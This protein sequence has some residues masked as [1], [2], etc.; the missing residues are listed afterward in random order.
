V[1]D[2]VLPEPMPLPPV[3]VVSGDATRRQ[4][5][6]VLALRAGLEVSGIYAGLDPESVTPGEVVLA[7]RDMAAPA[8]VVIGQYMSAGPGKAHL[9]PDATP[10]QLFAAALAV[11]AGLSVSSPPENAPETG[12]VEDLTPREHDVLRLLGE[13]LSNRAIAAELVISENTVKFHVASILGKLGA[14]TRAEA[15][16]NAVRNGLLPL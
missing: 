13:G 14:Q 7:D 11:V 6:A 8:L 16:M 15:V 2:P 9:R 10:A 12:V 1:L 3:V 5:L 4:G